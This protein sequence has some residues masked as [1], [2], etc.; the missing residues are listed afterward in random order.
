M[1]EK[2][3]IKEAYK[4]LGV[5]ENASSYEILDV[6]INTS[7]KELEK[8]R[9]KLVRK[10]HPDT[11]GINAPEE[12]KEIYTEIL[13]IINNA[14]TIVKE[15]I[16]QRPSVEILNDAYQ[17]LGVENG[18]PWYEIL[19][20]DKDSSLDEIDI[21]VN[22]LM[23]KYHPI[24]AGVSMSNELKTLRMEIVRIIIRAYDEAKKYHNKNE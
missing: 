1:V 4:R 5:A 21:V 9:G 2:R 10:Y 3:L 17:S 7:E 23:R 13:K 22:T 15:D 20:V 24:Y 16:N 6:Y 11:L 18:A 14:F 19:S 12:E 8:A